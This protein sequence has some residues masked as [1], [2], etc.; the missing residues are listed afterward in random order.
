MNNAQLAKLKTRLENQ[1][2]ENQQFENQQV[3]NQQFEFL[4]NNLEQMNEKTI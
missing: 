4:E 1:Q 3:E 2:F